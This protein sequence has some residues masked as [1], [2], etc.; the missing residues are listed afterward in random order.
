MKTKQP[1]INTIIKKE[2]E[3]GTSACTSKCGCAHRM[4]IPC[5]ENTGASLKEVPGLVTF[6]QELMI[7][8]D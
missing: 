6:E 7:V 1:K 4:M 5:Q 8:T 2:D 3:P